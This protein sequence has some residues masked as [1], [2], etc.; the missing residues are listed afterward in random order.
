VK[1]LALQ[2]FDDYVKRVR[3]FVHPHRIAELRALGA[4]NELVN[5]AIE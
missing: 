1:S 3:I 2:Q 5:E 4:T